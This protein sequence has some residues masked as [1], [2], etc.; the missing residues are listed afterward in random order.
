MADNNNS[1]K[2]ANL[3]FLIGMFRTFTVRTGNSFPII[4]V[5]RFIVFFRALL[6]VTGTG[7][8]YS[9]IFTCLY[10]VWVSPY[11][12]SAAAPRLDIHV[13]THTQTY[14]LAHRDQG[15]CH[16]PVSVKYKNLVSPYI[17]SLSPIY[18]TIVKYFLYIHWEPHQIVIIFA[19]LVRWNLENSRGK[20]KPILFPHIL[21]HHILYSFLVVQGSFFLN[22][23]VSV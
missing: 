19:L 10:C 8:F 6:W 12:L 21:A 5:F 13:Y 14:T 9:S 4:A 11:K 2:A 7:S 20:V 18:T 3:C 1:K 22:H 17:H 15:W 16:L 23:F